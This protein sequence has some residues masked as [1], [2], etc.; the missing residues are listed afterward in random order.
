MA[1]SMSLAQNILIA[2]DDHDAAKRAVEYV[3][4]FVAGRDDVNIHL[5]HALRP[6]PPQLMESPGAED[7]TREQQIE[8]RQAAQQKSWKNRAETQ[9]IPV[10]EAAKSQIVAAHIPAEN[11]ATQFLQLN[12]R[13]DLV[14][15]IIKA[16]HEYRCHTVVVGYNDY[17]WIKEKFHAHIA[18]Q[19]IAQS[20]RLAV[21]VVK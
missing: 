5:F 7:P 14:S 12:D 11:V 21:C 20:E 16:A 19:L 2:V 17:P 6:L 9:V 13:G 18:E 3:A 4:T 10:L 15:E 8:R 1:E